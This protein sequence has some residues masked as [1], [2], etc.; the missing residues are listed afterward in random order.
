MSLREYTRKR[1]FRRTPEPAPKR[2]A[3]RAVAPMFV[4]QKH[5][6]S[7]LHY[8]LRLE[9]DGALKSW[10][11]PKGMPLKHGEKRL[12]VQVED[13][14]LSYGRFEGTIPKGEY[15]GGT[16]LV[17][18]IGTFE[19]D[20]P[21]K[22]L[23]KGRLHFKLS[24]K[25]LN[26]EWSLVR[27][28]HE[29][30]NWLV[31]KHGE[32]APAISERRDNT[33]ALTGK[34]MSTIAAEAE[35]GETA[36]PEVSNHPEPAIVE[37]MMA[38]LVDKPPRGDWIYEV[39]FDGYRALAI[40]HGERIRIRSR[41][42]ND[43]TRTF[44]EIAQTLSRLDDESA[45][46]D[47]EIVALD[48]HGRPSFQ[49]LQNIDDPGFRAPVVYYVF[50]LLHVNGK[51]LRREPLLKRKKRLEKLVAGHTDGLR[52]SAALGADA[53][54]LLP[55]IRELGLEGLIGKRADSVY[56]GGRRS[57][58]WVKLKIVREQEFV[59]GGYTEP[60]GARKH[61]GSL[62]VGYYDRGALRYAGKVGSGFNL[63]TLSKLIARF[64]DITQKAC[65]FVVVP[66]ARDGAPEHAL[67]RAELKR[68]HWVKPRLVC[69][70]RFAEW[71]DD[72]KLRHPVYVGLRID[73]PARE[74]VRE[75]TPAV[76]T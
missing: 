3:A 1:N 38:K 59:I 67:S 72:G 39:K 50:D 15:G 28:G 10:A 30:S 73:K 76:R 26:G 9:V 34:R 16:V 4:I 60:S 33:S 42:G 20:E 75:E 5:A 11:V 63:E 64:E 31:I 2:K 12:A 61:F 54:V 69:H 21:L 44:P 74:V 48:D 43:L 32:D 25:K 66:E 24:G 70:V 14:P 23:R 7:R 68:S 13:H 58:A 18:D 40:K 47:G 37:P 45:I 55:R 6:A 57:G 41:N 17:W 71:T 19:A 8:D 27:F 65:P 22:G 46:L 36:P 56:E 49:A 51:D 52:Y 35:D 62:L 53:S 29:E